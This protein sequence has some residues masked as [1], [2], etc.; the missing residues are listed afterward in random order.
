MQKWQRWQ[1]WTALVVGVYAFLAPIWTT[2]DTKTTWTMV[3][4]GVITAAASLWSLASPAD[5]ALEYGHAVLGVLF[6]IAPWVLGFTALT[7]MA[8]TA[9]IVGII[10]FIVGVWAVP[11]SHHAHTVTA[12]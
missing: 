2:T 10:A 11:V 4:L 3:I 6:F 8:W 9:W 7:G 12:H 5:E 1:D